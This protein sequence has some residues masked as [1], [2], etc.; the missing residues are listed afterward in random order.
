LGTG[1]SGGVSIPSLVHPQA[2][3][4][5]S[6]PPTEADARYSDTTDGLQRLLQDVLAAAKNGDKEKVAAFAKGMAIPDCDAWLHKMYE[7]DKSD[8]W[9]GL[10]DPKV[11]ASKEQWMQELF[12]ETYKRGWGGLHSQSK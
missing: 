6:L 2:N 5:C 10:C 12:Y 9:M 4:S 8:S 1:R 11:L 3:K 7:P